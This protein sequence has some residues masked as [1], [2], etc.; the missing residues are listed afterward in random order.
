MTRRTIEVRVDEADAL[1][2]PVDVLAL[3]YAQRSYGVDAAACQALLRVHDTVDMPEVG[4]TVMYGG[5]PALQASQVLFV[6]VPPLQEF[7]YVEIREFGRL[8]IEA[9]AAGAPSAK[10]AALTLHGP[11]FGLDESEAFESELAGV[12]EALSSGHVPAQLSV[13]TFV[14][15]VA[16]RAAR[17][18]AILSSLLPNRR[19][20]VEGRATLG[21]LGA[22]AQSR[23]RSA[24]YS[25][26][27]KPHVFVAMPFASEMDD[28]FHYGIQGATNAAGLLCERADLSSFTGDVME[29]VKA[30][31]SSAK[32]VVADLSTANPNVYLEVGYA[33]GRGVPTVLLARDSQELKFDVRAQRCIVY[34]SI[35]HLEESLSRE[36]K[37]L[38]SAKV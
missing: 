17:L 37:A 35:K 32:L 12:I 20:Q 5:K 24:G 28:V 15:R 14:E 4:S 22:D 29:W 8:A 34:R 25:S 7:S 23:L 26:A 19:I 30:R 38:R 6:G 21:S 10:T 33:W 2:F 11:G 18:D 1:K 31:I 9:I 13:L 3:K 36:L 16:R 27:A